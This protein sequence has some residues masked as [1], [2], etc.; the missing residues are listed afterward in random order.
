MLDLKLLRTQ[1]E[2]IRALCLRR[3]APVDFDSLIAKDTEVRAL[4]AE[5][6][7]LRRKR[8]EGK[9][10]REAAIALRDRIGEIEEKLNLVKDERDLLWSLVPNFLAPDTPPG[11]DDK[12]NL[13]I[14]TW[15]DKPANDFPRLTHEVLGKSLGIIDEER[16]TKV[17]GSGY[18]YW[19]GDGARMAWGLFSLA[20]DLLAKQGFLQMFTPVVT[21]E[22]TLYGTG[23]LPFFKDQIYK[24]EGQDLNL[25]GTS[26]QTMVGYHMDE[27]LAAARLPRLYTSFTP[28]FR[29]EAGSYGKETR[30]MFR[31]HQFHKVEQIAYCTPETSEEWLQKTVDNV[32]EIMQLLEIPYRIVRVC[33]GDMGAPGYK[34]FDIEGWFSG[35]GA[36]RETHSCSN[37]LDYQARRLNVKAKQDKNTFI[38]HTIS[39]TMITDRAL[40]AILENNQRADGSVGIPKALRPYLAGR[41]TIEPVK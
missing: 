33:E 34:K 5:V 29:T 13:E 25:I 38:P 15:G 17:S 3:R 7:D 41:D 2:E 19:V 37:L 6:E 9:M 22:R 1:P 27:T 20:L 24:V 26:E 39:S 32:E 36:Y 23:Y 35:F 18:S 10:E 8:N 12:D 4:T 16:G 14:K 30:G 31:Q 21:R 40:L 11:A 28:C